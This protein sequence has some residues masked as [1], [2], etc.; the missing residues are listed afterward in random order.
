MTHAGAFLGGNLVIST[1]VVAALRLLLSRPMERAADLGWTLV[2]AMALTIGTG[3]VP[4]V[5]ALFLRPRPNAVR[6]CLWAWS[7]CLVAFSAL[8]L[9]QTV[10]RF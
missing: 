7:A 9:E 1:L 3:T 8:M 6:R 5:V 2:A 10:S 4:L